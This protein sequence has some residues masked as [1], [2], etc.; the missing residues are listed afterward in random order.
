MNW[1]PNNVPAAGDDIT[2]D[3]SCSIIVSA[4][5]IID[6]S[7]N[8][9]AGTTIDMGGKE[10]EIGK[11]NNNAIFSNDGT[12]SNCLKVK[13]KGTGSLPEGPFATNTGT[14]TA[15]KFEV[16]NNNGGG[17]VTNT[18]TGI[19]NVTAPMIAMINQTRPPTS[20]V[21]FEA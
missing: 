13:A 15:L 19:I 10:L 14:L 4:Y 6:G 7:L 17:V 16:G 12:I 20:S 3:C 21:T 11:T 18:A 2:I 1:N 8:I 5:L 9:A